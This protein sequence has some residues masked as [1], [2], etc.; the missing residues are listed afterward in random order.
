MAIARFTVQGVDV[1]LVRLHVLKHLTVV[2]QVHPILNANVASAAHPGILWLYHP[3]AGD[4]PSLDRD[5]TDGAGPENLNIAIPEDDILYHIGVHYWDS[6]GMG[7]AITTV[8]VW[9]YATLIYEGCAGKTEEE[10]CEAAADGGTTA[11]EVLEAPLNEL[12]MWCVG[13][14]NW[15]EPQVSSCEPL[16]PDT[17]TPNYVNPFFLSF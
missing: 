2:L 6:H 16:A 13:A 4:D 11:C 17:I 10:C 3:A 7:E 8:K 9:T 1:T 15:P 5:D 14:V 12:D